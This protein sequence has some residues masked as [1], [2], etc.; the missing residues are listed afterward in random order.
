METTSEYLE[1]MTKY[2]SGEITEKEMLLLESFV[3]SS[4]ENQKLFED[5]SGT[6]K[7]MQEQYVEEVVDA[8]K[9]WKLW[10]QKYNKPDKFNKSVGFRKI[11]TF[12]ASVAAILAVVILTSYFIISYLN[13][14]EQKTIYASVAGTKAVLPDGSKVVLDNGSSIVYPSKFS[15]EKRNISLSGE[16]FFEVAH[17]KEQPFIITSGSVCVEVLGT[18][19]NVNTRAGAGNVEVVVETGKVAVYHSLNPDYKTILEAGE[20]TLINQ[21]NFHDKPVVEQMIIIESLEVNDLTLS[22][23]ADLLKE[24]NEVNI[25]VD[26]SVSHLKMTASFHNQSLNSIFKVIEETLN[27]KVV[28]NEE[29]FL[30]TL[31]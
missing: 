20:K 21:Y 7:L 31:N 1:L 30:I 4:P 19:F 22:Q 6:W 3:K 14:V 13:R 17:N 9:E 25:V 26:K 15:G 10:Q 18:T 2:F 12:S 28:K 27:V 16:A 5:Y 24:K 8:E 23:I 29:Y 11:V